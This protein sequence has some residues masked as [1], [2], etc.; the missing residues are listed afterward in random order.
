VDIAGRVAAYGP[1]LVGQAGTPAPGE[2]VLINPA[3]GCGECRQCRRGEPSM[4]PRYRIIGE[5]SWGGLAEYVVAPARNV[6]PIPDHVPSEVAAAVPAV[7]TTAWRGVVTVARVRPSDTVLVVG[8]S[9]GLG[10]AQVQIAKA[11]G[12]RVIGT[13][14]SEEKRRLGLEI[15]A[16][17]MF[18]SRA[19]W[20][21]EVLA[22]TGGEGVDVAFDSVG[23][24]TLPHSLRCLAMGGR[25]VISGATGGD[26]PDLSV[27]EIYQRH[28]QILGAPMGGWEDFLQVT[29]LV[30]RGVLRPHVHA[31][32]P[33]EQTAEAQEE[34]E[35]R[36]HF[37]KIVVRVE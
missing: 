33:L 34:L 17:A 20:E 19:D 25:L 13:A 4:C 5:H 35:A 28:R 10:S 3:V 21:P 8:A 12:A 22:W 30:W 11:A 36:R 2:R 6:V 14:G 27:R 37:G 15:G 1:P 7:Y 9:G 16:D 31:V 32:Y 29:S 26:R 18:D 24:P 23:G